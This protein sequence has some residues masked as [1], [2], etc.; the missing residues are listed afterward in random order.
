M[1]ITLFNI[2]LSEFKMYN[3]IVGKS[4]ISEAHQ[5]LEGR[6]GGPLIKYLSI[7]LHIHDAIVEHPD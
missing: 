1:Q 2:D 7:K 3:L 4:L 5:N 6:R